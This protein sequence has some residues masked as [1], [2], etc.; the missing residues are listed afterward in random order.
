MNSRPE[1]LIDVCLVIITS[2]NKEKNYQV[3]NEDIWFIPGLF[4]Y[5]ENTRE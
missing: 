3:M 4:G 2:E 5:L 1:V